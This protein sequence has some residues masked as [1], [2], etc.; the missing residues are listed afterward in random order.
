MKRLFIGLILLSTPILGTFAEENHQNKTEVLRM[1]N[2]NALSIQSEQDLLSETHH[3]SH[4]HS[5]RGRDGGAFPIITGER[6]AASGETL[7]SNGATD[8]GNFVLTVLNETHGL[9]G[10]RIDVSTPG[11][12]PHSHEFLIG[13]VGDEYIGKGL[14]PNV[15]AIALKLVK[16][17]LEVT[18]AFTD[19][20]NGTGL[21]GQT[22]IVFPLHHSSH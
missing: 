4:S 9:A 20:I 19:V 17:H 22:R 21:Q 5:H 12:A 16:N 11:V 7:F 1:E 14:D 8:H 15:F 3:H 18:Y 10:I 6:F 13:R 2:A